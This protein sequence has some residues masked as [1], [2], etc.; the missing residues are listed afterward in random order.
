MAHKKTD[1]LAVGWRYCFAIAVIFVGL[2]MLYLKIGGEFLGFS[3]VGSWMIYIGFIMLAVITLQLFLNKKKIVDERMEFVA[4]KAAKI[5][6]T[7]IILFAFIVMIID[8]IRP[9][10]VAYS[11]FMSY[12]VCGIILIYLISYKILLRLH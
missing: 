11:Y 10:N 8:G 7:T 3:S 1:K 9:I 12:L 5:T 2:A 4:S 6:F